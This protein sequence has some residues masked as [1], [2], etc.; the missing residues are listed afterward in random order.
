MDL[1]QLVNSIAFNDFVIFLNKNIHNF[2]YTAK[3]KTYN[4]DELVKEIKTLKVQDAVT[5]ERIKYMNSIIY[6]ISHNYNEISTQYKFEVGGN[7]DEVIKKF[8]F[9]YRQYIDYNLIRKNTV[10]CN[11]LIK[12]LFSSKNRLI[13]PDIFVNSLRYISY[14]E[15]FLYS[16]INN[17]SITLSGYEDQFFSNLT[18]FQKLSQNFISQLWFC[19]RDK[20]INSG[21][22]CYNFVTKQPNFFNIQSQKI[23]NE[24]KANADLYLKNNGELR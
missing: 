2:Y 17:E 18:K 5:D 11:F 10:E 1:S 23:M 13:Y 4:L 16:I 19:L 14:S 20:K 22:Y 9:E 12:F 7:F 8:L 6:L 24:I 3:G 21:E 15:I